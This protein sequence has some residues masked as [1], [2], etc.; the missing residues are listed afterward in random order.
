MQQ[1]DRDATRRAFSKPAAFVTLDKGLTLKQELT[2]ARLRELLHYDPETGVFTWLVR[3]AHRIQVGDEAGTV[4]DGYRNIK[5]EGRLHKAHRLAWLYVAGDWPELGIDHRNGIG[6]DNRFENLR[7]ATQ[8]QNCQNLKLN[9]NN[10]SGH[11][12]VHWVAR[13]SLWAARI[14][15]NRREVHIGYFKSLELAAAARRD[16]KRRFHTFN[17]EA[18]C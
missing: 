18:R 12:G 7:E 6:T 5:V 13:C 4:V 8:A 1:A 17:P 14:M 9:K 16:A 2:A 10:S 3:A 11:P 15:V